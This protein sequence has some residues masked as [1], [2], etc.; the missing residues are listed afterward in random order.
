MLTRADRGRRAERIA[1]AAD[2]ATIA[3]T[4]ALAPDRSATAAPER[5][6]TAPE[7]DAT[8]DRAATAV[9]PATAVK[10]ATTVKPARAGKAATSTTVRGLL[11]GIQTHRRL[12]EAAGEAAEELRAMPMDAVETLRGMGMFSLK[13]PTELGGTQLNPLDFCEV[14]EELAY[15]DS[16]TAWA[17]MIGSGCGGL[18]GGWLPKAGA[19]IV[20]SS[21][22]PQPVIAGQ[23]Q[24]RGTGRMTSEGYVVTGHWNFA[25]GITHADWLIGAFAEQNRRGVTDRILVFVCPKEQAEI[26]DTWQVAGLRGTGSMDFTL[27]DVLVP[28]D[29]TYELGAEPVRGGDLFRLGMPAFVA[30]EVPPF[31]IGM[32]RRALYDMTELADQTARFSGGPTLSDRAVFRKEVGRAEVRLKAARLVHRDAVRVVW[33]TA[34]RGNTPP[35][36]EQLALTAASVYAVETCTDVICDLFRYGGGRV[37]SLA[38]PVQRHLRNALAA[39]QHVAVSEEFYEAAGAEFIERAKHE[40]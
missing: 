3:D 10:P 4:T 11:T 23:L 1:T 25:S 18:A 21:G 9:R 31:C 22:Q 2:R 30:N 24:P 6:A 20:F 38:N 13:T 37:L 36:S 5:G 19:R 12:F 27:T 33:E 35:E 34:Q 16:S 40:S 28:H 39:R 8:S 15:V 7:R 14:I 32:A 26:L 29:M 17:A